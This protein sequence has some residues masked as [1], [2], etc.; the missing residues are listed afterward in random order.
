MVHYDIIAFLNSKHNNFFLTGKIK[1]KLL[2]LE[3]IKL[4]HA[5]L[6]PPGG[7]YVGGSQLHFPPS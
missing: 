7:F 3:V 2:I 6:I 1:A 5:V 4:I